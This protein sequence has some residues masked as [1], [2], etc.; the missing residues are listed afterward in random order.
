MNLIPW[1]KVKH[2]F[3][4]HPFLIE[5]LLKVNGFFCVKR[6]SSGQLDK[7]KSR[8]VAQGYKQVLH[9]DFSKIFSPIVKKVTIKIILII[10]L[11][12]G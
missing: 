5:K 9:F 8:V 7:H 10:A 2:G 1:L 12:K 4:L 3:L 6:L 11:S